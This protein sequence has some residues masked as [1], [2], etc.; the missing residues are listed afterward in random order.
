[1]I[2]SKKLF[3]SASLLAFF[4]FTGTSCR[5]Q[6]TQ[7]EQ[8]AVITSIQ[9]SLY[10]SK[11]FLGDESNISFTVFVQDLQN[12]VIWDSA[13]APMKAKEIPGIANTLVIQKTVTSPDRQILKAGF[14]YSI[15]NVG[16]S[17]FYDTCNAGASFKEIKFNFQ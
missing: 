16:N 3:V 15:E 10:T 1:M 4:I 7:P 8:E 6:S 2:K 11:D 5:K 9:F 12:Q 14:K 13:L 17:W